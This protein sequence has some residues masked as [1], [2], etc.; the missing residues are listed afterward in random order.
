MEG[1]DYNETFAPMV[2]LT[3]AH[4]LLA[5]AAVRNWKLHKM[6]VHNAFLHGDLSE[7]VY[8]NLPPGFRP[9]ASNMV[10][11]CKSISTVLNNLLVIGSPNS[12]VP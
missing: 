7:E 8:M 5:V 12:L 3:T 4:K 11:D 2:K 6:D 10:C 1:I 9:Q